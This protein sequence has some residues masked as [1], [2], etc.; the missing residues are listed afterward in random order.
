MC[1]M[2]R[3]WALA[4]TSNGQLARRKQRKNV[5]QR[6][7]WRPQKRMWK[8]LKEMDINVSYGNKSI[9]S[10]C[11]GRKNEKTR[12]KPKKIVFCVDVEKTSLNLYIFHKNIRQ[13]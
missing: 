2:W 10:A 1:E 13:K 12:K 9:K 5:S 8:C 11:F 3:L 6:S 4:C 7:G